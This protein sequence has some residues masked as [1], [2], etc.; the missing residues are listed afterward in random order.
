MQRF[1]VKFQEVAI[2]RTSF[3]ELWEAL[4]PEARV[5]IES[6]PAGSQLAF[7]DPLDQKHAIIIVPRKPLSNS[8]RYEVEELTIDE[9]E[10][11]G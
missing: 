7:V 1:G 10:G 4:G 5:R 11:K 6:H 3:D 2:S 9:I 8:R